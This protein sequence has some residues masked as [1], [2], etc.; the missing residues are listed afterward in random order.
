MLSVATRIHNMYK[1]NLFINAIRLKPPQAGIV[2]YM[3]L[4][5]NGIKT[6]CYVVVIAAL[7]SKGHIHK[8]SSLT[9]FTLQDCSWMANTVFFEGT[10][11]G[12]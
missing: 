9:A 3:W 1:C 2:K 6:E 5:L 12:T 8:E 10:A 11:S 7:N 4:V